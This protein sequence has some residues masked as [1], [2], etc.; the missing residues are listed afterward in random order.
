MEKIFYLDIS[1]STFFEQEFVIIRTIETR[2]FIK[3]FSLENIIKAH[4]ILKIS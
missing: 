3:I 1:K 2:T 4:K